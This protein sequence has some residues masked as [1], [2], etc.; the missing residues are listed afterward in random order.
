MSVFIMLEKKMGHLVSPTDSK[1]I[2]SLTPHPK[3][4]SDVRSEYSILFPLPASLYSSYRGLRI[5]AIDKVSIRKGHR[6]LT[7]VLDYKTGRVVW[8]G[9]GRKARTLRRFFSGMSREQRQKLEAVV[10]VLASEQGH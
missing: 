1:Y 6:Y 4:A 7:V 9:E 5:L 8:V 2:T 3:E 10:S